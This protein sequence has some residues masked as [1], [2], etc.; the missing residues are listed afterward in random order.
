M[1]GLA[2]RLRSRAAAQLRGAG[3]LLVDGLFPPYCALCDRPAGRQILLC[4]ECE[5]S[6]LLNH[7][8]CSRCALPD[9][10]NGA[11]PACAG[12]ALAAV[13][14]V[15]AP[16]VYDAALGELV[17]RWKYQREL[18]LTA[19]LADLW[20]RHAHPATRPQRVVPVP[21][22]WQR[23]WWRG[24]NQAERLAS[25]LLQESPELSRARL[26]PRLLR[27]RRRTAAQAR[28]GQRARGVNL[29]DAFTSA[30]PCDNLSFALIDDVCTTGATAD[31]AAR[32]LKDAGAARVELW[33]LARAPTPP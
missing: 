28:L 17:S 5:H 1:A 25:A 32:C 2:D 15:H 3:R 12:G 16:F 7:S 29:A 18:A 13:D 22:H 9:A 19:L 23:L 30:E 14:R 6:L 27:R 20:L 24:F 4:D 10:G 33:C 11:C 31:A 8:G 26:R 21:L